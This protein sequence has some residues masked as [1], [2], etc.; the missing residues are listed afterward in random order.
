MG[1]YYKA[2]NTKKQEYVC[3]WC[4]CGGAKLWE[5]AANTQGSIFTLLLQKSSAIEEVDVEV[6]REI[7]AGRWAGDPIFLVGDYDDSG[8]YR[9]AERYRNISEPLVQEWNRF[10]DHRPSRL[11]FNPCGCPP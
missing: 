8:L 4:I 10:L 1:Q 11:T 6:G 7:M 9:K 2:V 5:W 3:P